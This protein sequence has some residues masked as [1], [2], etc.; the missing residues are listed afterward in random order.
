MALA[1]R[2]FEDPQQAVLGR[3]VPDDAPVARPALQSL[4]VRTPSGLDAARG[5]MRWIAARRGP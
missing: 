5:L 1:R 4:F 3:Y 2:A